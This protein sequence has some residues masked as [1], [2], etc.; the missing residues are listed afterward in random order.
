MAREMGGTHTT[1][2]GKGHAQLIARMEKKYAGL[3][4]NEMEQ[5]WNIYT[6]D[7]VNFTGC[8]HKKF[9]LRAVTNKYDHDKDENH[10]DNRIEYKNWE[11]NS[12]TYVCIVEYYKN[13]PGYNGVVCYQPEDDC[14]SDEPG[15][16]WEWV[17]KGKAELLLQG[18]K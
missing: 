9:L 8:R 11:I 15:N 7:E 10:P 3:K 2:G 5:G 14:D 13:D 17:G 6:I 18:K 1:G 12:M 16:E 4:L